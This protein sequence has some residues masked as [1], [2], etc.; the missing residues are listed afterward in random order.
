MSKRNYEEQIE[1]KLFCFIV[2]SYLLIRCSNVLKL[3]L[4]EM[5]VVSQHNDMDKTVKPD[6]PGHFGEPNYSR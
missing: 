1:F 6:L 2:S 4:L 5:T 3:A